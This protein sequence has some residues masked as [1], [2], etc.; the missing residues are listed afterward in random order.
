M[1]R[2]L[3]GTLAVCLILLTAVAPV[4]A[5]AQSQPANETAT[6]TTATNTTAT[7]APTAAEQVRINPV[8]LDVGYQS[9]T[10]TEADATFNTT[11]EFVLF[12]TTEP[13]DAVRI[14][15]SKAQARV[16]EGGQTVRV[17][18]DADAAPPEQTS[19]YTLELF[20]ADGSAKDV[21]LYA[22]DTEQSVAAA[23]L[24]DWK[25]TIE[26]LKDKAE[27]NGYEETP[28]G[29]QEYVTWVDDR[30]QLV[31][32]FLSEL[33]AQTIGWLIAGVMNPLNIIL[34]LSLGALA[35]WRRRSKHGDLVDALSS[36][37]GRYEQELTKLRNN[38]EKAKRTADDANLS[39]V[40]AIG[41]A[42]DY[43]EDAFGTKSPAQLA[44]LANDGAARAT[45]DGL[46]YV[47]RGVDDL[48]AEDLHGTWLEPVLRH[49]PNE[50]RVLNHL[51]ET[52]KYMETEHSLGSK[53]RETRNQLET[54]LDDVDRKQTQLNG[55]AAPGDD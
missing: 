24:Q 6:N 43:Y 48:D 36:M 15:Q 3:L 8:S 20:F 16:L 32:G 28:E 46:E 52:V 23:S 26:T 12:S 27:E 1:N 30:A 9:V 5:L 49:I 51:L 35:M 17:T 38:R 22:S 50:K 33:A 47:H 44:D 11:G 55:V 4:A 21:E 14:Q 29:T 45:D 34:A 54:M 41:S 25:P 18:Y 40:P 42:A 39:E 53:Y 19:L 7:D 13:V 2:R 37:A 10:V 31:E